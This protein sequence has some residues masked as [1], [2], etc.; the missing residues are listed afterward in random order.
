MKESFKT[1]LGFGLTSGVITT[2]GLMIGLSSGTQSVPIIIGG[3]LTIAIAD[4]FSDAL[5][6][7]V[8]EEAEARHTPREIWE[9]TIS[10]FLAKFSIAL[11]FVV[12]LILFQLTTAVVA[13]IIWGFLLLGLFSYYLAREEKISPAKVILEHLGIAIV[14]I[15]ITH[16]VGGW[17]GSF[18]S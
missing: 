18:F 9:A 8:S 11:S 2:L 15:I 16:L 6:I 5:G 1:G 10:A 3:I 7:H 14:V 13:S 12:P 4:A 17:I